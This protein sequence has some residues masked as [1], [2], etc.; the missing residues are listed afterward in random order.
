MLSTFCHPTFISSLTLLHSSP[1]FQLIQQVKVGGKVYS[2]L[3]A[4]FTKRGERTPLLS[5]ASY[6]QQ[7][8]PPPSAPPLSYLDDNAPW[9]VEREWCHTHAWWT[10]SDLHILLCLPVQLSS[11]PTFS[12]SHPGHSLLEFELLVSFFFFYI[13]WLVFLT[14]YKFPICY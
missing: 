5:S 12:L 14:L 3:T 8:T 7:V 10:T 9:R 13:P 1:L 4:S 2:P 6:S 11:A